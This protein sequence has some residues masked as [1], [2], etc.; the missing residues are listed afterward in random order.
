MV[1]GAGVDYQEKREGGNDAGDGDHRKLGEYFR[2]FHN[3]IPVFRHVSNAAATG[4]HLSFKSC[5]GLLR[6][7]NYSLLG[8][9]AL[10]EKPTTQ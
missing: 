5:L 1:F 6:A 4:F 7:V 8:V 2:W 9:G 10:M 3:E